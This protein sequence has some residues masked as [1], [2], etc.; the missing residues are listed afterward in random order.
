MKKIIV[1]SAFYFLCASAFAAELLGGV[2]FNTGLFQ[3]DGTERYL[4]WTNNGVAPVYVRRLTIEMGMGYNGLGDYIATVNRQ[5]DGTIL[6]RSGW[7][8]YGNPNGSIT[9]QYSFA[10]DYFIVTSGDRLW[11]TYNCAGFSNPIPQA[12]IVITVNYALSP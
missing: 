8:R 5:S 4:A 12:A 6:M 10:P 3:C 11:L 7:D 1:A 2:F 9:T